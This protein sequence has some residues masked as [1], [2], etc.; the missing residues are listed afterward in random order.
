MYSIYEYARIRGYMQIQ[1]MRTNTH[2]V[3]TPIS[4][5]MCTY[6]ITQ[7]HLNV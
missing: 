3:Y 7:T 1:K 4:T 2:R 5:Y 6:K